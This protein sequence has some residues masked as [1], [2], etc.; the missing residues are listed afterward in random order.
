MGS[1]WQWPSIPIIEVL[2]FWIKDLLAGKSDPI[3]ALRSPGLT[4]R[5][6]ALVRKHEDWG[7]LLSREAKARPGDPPRTPSRGD[8]IVDLKT[9]RVSAQAEGWTIPP[10]PA[11]NPWQVG[12]DSKS[13][14]LWR[15]GKPEGQVLLQPGDELTDFALSPP[16]PGSVRALP[17]L[18][19]AVLD[20]FGAPS[21]KLYDGLSGKQVRELSGHTDAVRGLTFS[22]DGRWLI[23]ASED[24]TVSAWDLADLESSLERLKRLRDVDLAPAD[25]GLVVRKASEGSSLHAGDQVTGIV[26]DG[27]GILFDSPAGLTEAI[28]RNQPGQSVTLWRVRPGSDPSWV[29]VPLERTIAE[30]KPQLSLFFAPGQPINRHGGSPGP[31]QGPTTSATRPSRTSWAGTSTPA[32]LTHP[33]A[34][35][36][37]PC[38][39]GFG[40]GGL[41]RES[42][43]GPEP[44]VPLL[45]PEPT[46]CSTPRIMATA[47]RGSGLKGS[48]SSSSTGC[49]RSRPSSPSACRSTPGTPSPCDAPRPAPGRPNSRGVGSIRGGGTW[50]WQ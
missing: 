38:I 28:F 26:Q 13:V 12:Y 4:I 36:W 34:S 27:K 35:R 37:R 11:G 40:S 48:I 10:G 47:C 6:A 15:Q 21:L 16:G 8:F 2:I 24:Q 30:R 43:L 23:S 17:V 5:Q 50:P 25:R 49:S 22:G 19:V 42:I 45:P 32:R 18:A 7:L 14:A 3:Q 33:P 39:A 29:S 1:I 9:G 20:R 46:S 44:P 41:L 31:H